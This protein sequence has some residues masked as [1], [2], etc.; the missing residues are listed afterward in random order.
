MSCSS[1]SSPRNN[2]EAEVPSQYRSI[3]SA[4]DPGEPSVSYEERLNYMDDDKQLE[5]EFYGRLRGGPRRDS[6]GKTSFWRNTSSS[7][8]NT[9]TNAAASANESPNFSSVN[10]LSARRRNNSS[11]HD[12]GTGSNGG[13]KGTSLLTAALMEQET[14][15][16]DHTPQSPQTPSSH[17]KTSICKTLQAVRKKTN[18]YLWLL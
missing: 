3:R 18:V 8:S 10:L 14:A 7:N 9:P 1:S 16:K 2:A 17:G 15:H 11:R 5:E 6:G 13:G 12:R 4:P